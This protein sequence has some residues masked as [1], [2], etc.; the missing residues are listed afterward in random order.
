LNCVRG[1]SLCKI[2]NGDDAILLGGKDVR[3]T[4]HQ[5]KPSKL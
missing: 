2:V 5:I 4:S 1:K 3:K